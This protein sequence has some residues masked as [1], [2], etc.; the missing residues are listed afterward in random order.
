MGEAVLAE[1]LTAL[2]RAK[3]TAV[4]QLDALRATQER[5]AQA[6]AA[7]V[8]GERSA[9]AL[10]HLTRALVAIEKS[11]REAAQARREEA[12]EMLARR[13]AAAKERAVEDDGDD[14]GN[15]DAFRLELTRR[16]ESLRRQHEG[17]D[18]VSAAELAERRR[19]SEPP[20][21]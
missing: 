19:H 3:A 10:N 9:R 12:A 5:V 14:L 6:A 11:E 2:E 7:S 1:R 8:D 18:F 15:L 20:R 13:N 21:S 4:S 17:A 16:L